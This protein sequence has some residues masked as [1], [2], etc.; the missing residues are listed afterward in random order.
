MR[1]GQGRV[2][3]TV[4]AVLTAL[5]MTSCDSSSVSRSAQRGSPASSAEMQSKAASATR[6]PARQTF[7]EAV[8]LYFQRG[9][10]GNR[11]Q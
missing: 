7:A 9:G 11:Q 2:P 10:A 4:A 5:A 6:A 1:K 8:A 3:V